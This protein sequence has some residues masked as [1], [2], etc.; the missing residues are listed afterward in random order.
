MA[1]A[2]RCYKTAPISGSSS[3][4]MGYFHMRQ[5][6]FRLS[7]LYNSDQN[8]LEGRM[9]SHTGPVSSFSALGKVEI[10]L[11]HDGVCSLEPDA[12]HHHIRDS[13]L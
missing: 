6:A 8:A 12:S 3:T 11:K 1:Y 4:A 7:P 5:S 2:Q 9:Q 10:R 13:I